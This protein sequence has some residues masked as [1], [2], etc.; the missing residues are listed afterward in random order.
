ML[1]CVIVLTI[2]QQST[3]KKHYH[4]NRGY[5]EEYK[6]VKLEED[7]VLLFQFGIPQSHQYHKYENKD[8]YYDPSK[9]SNCSISLNTH[10]KTYIVYIIYLISKYI[11]YCAYKY[12]YMQEEVLQCDHFIIGK[13]TTYKYQQHIKLITTTLAPNYII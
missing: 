3:L 2:T 1:C 8:T 4:E 11:I 9:C 10:G 5:C 7:K 6:K 13:S 12:K